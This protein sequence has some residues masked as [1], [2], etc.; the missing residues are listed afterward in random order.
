MAARRRAR[1]LSRAGTP[2]DVAVVGAGMVGLATA[3]FLQASGA[4]VTVYERDRVAAGASWGNAGWL[5]P[6]LVAPLPEPA[7]LRYGL[8]AVLDPSSP[9]YLPL[10]A[11][12]GMLRFLASFTRHSTHRQWRRG[13]AAFVPLNERALGAFDAL[14]AGGVT[15]GTRPS[16]PLLAVYRTEREREGLLAEL[17]AVQETGQQDVVFGP[18]TGAEARA[19]EPA[20][21]TEA[22]SAVRISGQRYLHPPEYVGS[23]AAAVRAQGG[24]VVEGSA[25]RDLRDTGNGV[26]VTTETGERPHDAVVIATGAWLGGLARRFGVRQRVQAG[27]GYSFSVPVDQMPAGPLYF[28]SQRVACTPLGDRLRVAGMMEF[29][30]PGEPL[31][32][33]RIMAIVDAVRPFLSGVDLDDRRDEWVGSRPCTGDGL[34]LLGRTAAPHV[35]VAGG[36]GMWGMVLGPVTGMLM[37]QTVL[38]GEAPAELRPFDPLR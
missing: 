6:S 2:R 38:K 17:Q 20:L 19:L 23:L 5:P 24:T 7:V 34:P 10:R 31:D 11:D 16:E 22:G 14:A 12:A 37:A 32:P 21:T 13:M 33:R 15:A 8:K 28:P 35:F 4:R 3:W 27:R 1:P 26:V 18:V 36:H 9:V 25:V 30:R 29:R